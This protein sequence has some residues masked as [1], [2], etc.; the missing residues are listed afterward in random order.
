MNLQNWLRRQT[1]VGQS[2]GEL[3]AEFV[4]T[5]QE[6]PFA[7]LV[8]RHNGLV[9]GVCL[10]VLRHMHDAED[11]AQAV[12]L[13]LAVKA[14]SL[15]N[16][17]SVAGWLHHVAWHV[18]QRARE[19]AGVR[20]KHEG[21]AGERAERGQGPSEAWDELKPVLDHA[22]DALPEKYRLPL[23]LHH[24][25]GKTQ[26]EA[27]KQLGCKPGT[28]S[29]RLH[30]GR[31][32]LR[33]RLTRQGVVLS[34]GLLTTLLAENAVSAALPGPTIAATVKAGTLLAAGQAAATGLVSAH[35]AALTQG[36]VRSMFLFRLKITAALLATVAL[37]GTG[38]GVLSYRLLA[39]EK[40]VAE[41]KEPALAADEP[42]K[43]PPAPDFSGVDKRIQEILP[44]AKERRFDEIG[45]AKGIREAERLAKES[46]R[47]V[48]LF[49][50]VG[51]MDI[52]RC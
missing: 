22:I 4:A 15:Q 46:N 17:T 41:Q 28:L 47:P 26:E 16:R 31:E 43:A 7:E 6:A 27:A 9:L 2:D 8:R 36:A 13:T 30:R 21:E 10:R 5:G 45:W 24:F 23:I 14:S 12:F 35:V 51:Q 11:A 39:M 29:A 32:M 42:A 48:F 33:G 40:A 38:T 1:C 3:L 18:G 25:Q 44:T 20:K 19:A 50:N 37:V 49:S 52:G 34:T